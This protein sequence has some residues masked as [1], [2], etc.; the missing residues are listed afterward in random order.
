MNNPYG[1]G[2]IPLMPPGPPP[3]MIGNQ[4]PQNPQ[5]N[6]AQQGPA[7]Q[8]PGMIYYRAPHRGSSGCTILFLIVFLTYPALFH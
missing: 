8:P 4:Q 7:L 3:H 1:F 6:S 5:S 2:N